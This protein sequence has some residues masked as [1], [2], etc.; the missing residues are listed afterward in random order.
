MGV[1]TYFGYDSHRKLLIW[2]D[3]TKKTVNIA[4]YPFRKDSTR[5]Q[6]PLSFRTIYTSP[7]ELA[8]PLSVDVANDIFPK[9]PVGIYLDKGSVSELWGSVG[10]TDLSGV[11]EEDMPQVVEECF[12]LGKCLGLEGNWVCDCNKDQHGNCL[13]KQCPKGLAWF[14]KPTVDN[15]AHD[16]LVECSAMGVC[17]HLSGQCECRDGFEGAA[18]ERLSCPGG[19]MVN[20]E[21]NGGA[22]IASIP[23]NNAG[24]C[25]SLSSMARFSKTGEL[26]YHSPPTGLATDSS[27]TYGS[28]G[29]RDPATWEA[30]RLHGC[31]ADTYGYYPSNANGVD[32]V[33]GSTASSHDG[34]HN[35]T[36]ATGY[37]LN[38]KICPFTYN[39]AA[40]LN[41]FSADNITA[42]NYTNTVQSLQCIATGGTFSLRFRDAESV[43]VDAS[44]ALLASVQFILQSMSTVGLVHITYD[45]TSYDNNTALCAGTKAT[46]PIVYAAFLTEHGDLPLLELDAKSALTGGSPSSTVALAMHSEP[47]NIDSLGNSLLVECGGHGDCNYDTGECMCW[48]NWGSS[49]GYSGALGNTGDCGYN[50]IA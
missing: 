37:K 19:T 10:R 24:R 2:S 4:R 28:T 12:G 27:I 32:S 50:R 39:R 22:A 26:A 17:N 1:P 48:P 44:T 36:A 29:S 8:Y 33:T 16:E 40:L 15:V 34:S 49:D 45:S 41:S 5:A 30:H 11:D 6:D 46:A 9:I 18:C 23:C 35:I 25:M 13:A 14:N 43:S 47:P 7:D 31:V 21:L 42:N 3:T 38:K 20:P